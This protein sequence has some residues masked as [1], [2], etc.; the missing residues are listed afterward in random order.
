MILMG[1]DD[2]SELVEVSGVQWGSRL[3]PRGGK[4]VARSLACHRGVSNRDSEAPPGSRTEPASPSFSLSLPPVVQGD[5]SRAQECLMWIG[6]T[7]SV[8]FW[9][10]KTMRTVASSYEDTLSWIPRPTA[11]SG[12][13]TTPR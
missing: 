3:V 4:L 8:G 2:C 7:E 13:W 5:V 11:S 1:F 9:I 12:T 6:R 10:L